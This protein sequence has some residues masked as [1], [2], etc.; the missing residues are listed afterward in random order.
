MNRMLLLKLLVR[1]SSRT[2]H[3]KS[4]YAT[5]NNRKVT[6]EN[7]PI[8][9]RKRGPHVNQF[10]SEIEQFI[11]TTSGLKGIHHF[12]ENIISK[13]ES[14]LL[15]EASF[16]AIFMRMCLACR[17]YHLGKQFLDYINK[18][19]RQANTAT[20]TRFLSL[21]YFC[22]EEVEDKSEVEKLCISLSSRNQYL[23][24]A[25]KESIILGWSITEKWQ[26]GLELLKEDEAAHYS[27][28]MNAIVDCLLRHND[29]QTAVLWMDK[30]IEKERPISDFVYEHWVKKCAVHHT[31][32]NIFTDFLTNHGVFLKQ[33]IIQQLKDMLVNRP[34]DSFMGHLTS[35]DEGT[36][37]CQSCQKILQNTDINDEEFAALRERLTD[38]VLLGTDVFLG[39]KPEEM[40]RFKHLIRDAKPYDIV[41]DGLNVAYHTST[42]NRI[43]PLGKVEAVSLSDDILLLILLKSL[44][45]EAAP[46]GGQTL[47]KPETASSRPY[48]KAFA[49]RPSSK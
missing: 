27:L 19:G 10:E 20:L 2:A 23:D 18:A 32:W 30:M 16:D 42:K 14:A 9:S 17:K 33:S 35:I 26:E 25:T 21:C 4:T 11:K 41:I 12:R 24:G 13:Y 15:T 3:L 48:K 44:F 47:Y 5:F 36:G 40:Q 8:V 39:S 46:V 7:V 6:N 34:K 43:H 1:P 22:S 37:R 31:C 38:K 29:F 45:T 28:A 49:Y